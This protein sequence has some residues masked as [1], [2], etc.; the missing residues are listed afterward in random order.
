MR[1][2]GGP[3][4]RARRMLRA[5][6]GRWRI[7]YGDEFIELLLAD[8]T[9]RP[10]CAS[11]SF[12]VYRGGLIAR[13]GGGG[14]VGPVTDP[15]R[16]ASVNLAVLGGALSIFLLLGV[17]VWAQLAIGWQWAAPTAPTTMM[18]MVTMSAGVLIFAVL[19]LMAALP[20]IATVVNMV[21]R[22][23]AHDLVRPLLL[24][25]AG[26]LVMIIGTRHFANGWPGTT[27][28]PWTHQGL[29]PGGVAAFAWAATLS[30]TSYWAHPSALG[31]F[32]VGEV[33]WMVISPV[34]LMAVAVGVVKVVRRVDLSPTALRF[35]VRIGSAAAIVMEIFLAAAGWWV[36]VGGAGPRGLFRTGSIDLAALVLMMGAVVLAFWATQ[37]ARHSRILLGAG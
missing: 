28:H 13:L 20:I 34:A 31:T 14:L 22:H 29:V 7:Q 16:Q 6:P 17:S 18:A 30:I 3:E 23:E 24:A 2:T 33:A 32:P 12:D 9:E 8:L 21:R 26:A 15:A 25:A 10:H 4:A 36:I 35:E 37:R 5:Y 11:R 1:P 19:A 27:G